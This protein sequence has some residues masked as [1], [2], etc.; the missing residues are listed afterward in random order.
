MG[1]ELKDWEKGERGLILIGAFIGSVFLKKM[2]IK[3]NG[4]QEKKKRK[5]IKEKLQDRRNKKGF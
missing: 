4:D 2:M 5:S 1:N 3:K